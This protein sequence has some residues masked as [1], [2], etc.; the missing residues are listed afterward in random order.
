MGEGGGISCVNELFTKCWFLNLIL[1]WRYFNKE[2]FSTVTFS[3]TFL[4]NN[5]FTSR[6]LVFG[7]FCLNAPDL[8]LLV[9]LSSQGSVSFG[10]KCVFECGNMIQYMW[11]WYLVLYSCY[12]RYEPNFLVSGTQRSELWMPY[13]DVMFVHLSVCDLLPAPKPLCFKN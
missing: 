2:L 4:I 5:L 6:L 11:R 1:L 12:K 7:Y 10:R 13:M 9:F 3:S 8:R